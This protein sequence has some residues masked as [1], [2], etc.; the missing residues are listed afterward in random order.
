MRIIYQLV[1]LF[2]A[3]FRNNR[4]DD[5][6]ADEMRFHVERETD[7]HVARGM[8]PEAARR[9]ARLKFGSVDVAQEQSRDDRPGALARQIVG[10]V[11]FGAR[12]LAKSPV[13]GIT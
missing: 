7:A 11:R 1:A 5:D 4:V 9:A 13:F 12:L 2:R 10:D 3:L 6:L 8:S